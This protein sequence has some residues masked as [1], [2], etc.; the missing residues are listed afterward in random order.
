LS[1][2]SP[3]ELKMPMLL[4]CCSPGVLLLAGMACGTMGGGRGGNGGGR[5]AQGGHRRRDWLAGRAAHCKDT[6]CLSHLLLLQ[7]RWHTM[8]FHNGYVTN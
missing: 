2:L 4:P 3:T 7:H 1:H 8:L 5:G 6:P